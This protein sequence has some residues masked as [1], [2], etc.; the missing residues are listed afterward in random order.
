MTFQHRAGVTPYTSS[1]DLAE[2][3]VLVKQLLGPIYCGSFEHPLLRTYGV[4]LPSSLATVLSLSLGYSPRPPVSVLVRAANGLSPEAFLETW[5]HTLHYLV[6][7]S[8]VTSLEFRI[9]ICLY[10]IYTLAMP[11]PIRTRAN[12]LCH[13]I[14]SYAGAG[15][16]TC[17][18]STTPLGL[19]LAP[20]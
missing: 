20:D 13:S 12:L 14:I 2:S 10:T 7:R 15:I 5:Y 3:Y 19:A 17:W 18:S 16:S 6:A 8:L 1:C 4:I 9:R 11:N